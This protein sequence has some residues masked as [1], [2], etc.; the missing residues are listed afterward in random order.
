MAGPRAAALSFG[1]TPLMPLGPP[2]KAP[3]M[4]G[5]PRI[6]PPPDHN[7]VLTPQQPGAPIPPPRVAP[8]GVAPTGAAPTKPSLLREPGPG[9]A[10]NAAVVSGLPWFYTEGD[11]AAHFARHGSVRFARLYEDVLNGK[12]RGIVLVQF[13]ALESLTQLQQAPGAIGP[14]PV[15]VLLVNVSPQWDP[16]TAPPPFPRDPALGS[17]ARRAPFGYGP[18]LMDVRGVATGEA[19]TANRAGF[20]ELELARKRWRTEREQRDEAEAAAAGA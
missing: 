20:A 14:Y 1:A 7:L 11:A 2:V 4:A 13:H 6:V 3:P 10:A 12:S 8:G 15:S 16:L 5:G 18:Q 9:V 19:N 17:I